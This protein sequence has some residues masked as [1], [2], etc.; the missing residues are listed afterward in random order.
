MFLFDETQSYRSV[1]LPLRRSLHPVICATSSSI[2]WLT[3]YS[4]R[5]IRAADFA[6]VVAVVSGAKA[7]I[8]SAYC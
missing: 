8:G 1:P 4:W 3:C 6:V 7:A 5:R 2:T